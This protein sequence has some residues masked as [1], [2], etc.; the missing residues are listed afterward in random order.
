MEYERISKVRPWQQLFLGHSFILI[1][2]ATNNN[3]NYQRWAWHIPPAVEVQQQA[4]TR[5][6]P[7]YVIFAIGWSA[8]ISDKLV[9]NQINLFLTLLPILVRQEYGI[10]LTRAAGIDAGTL[11]D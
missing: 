6:F 2:A 3:Y 9:Q 5:K 11:S 8:Q 10:H 1:T 7:I 4:Y